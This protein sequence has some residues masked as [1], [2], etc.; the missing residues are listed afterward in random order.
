MPSLMIHCP[1]TGKPLSTGINM[2]AASFAS[3][4]L[5]D[6]TTTCPHCGQPH[7]WNKADVLPIGEGPQEPGGSPK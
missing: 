7:T 3:S 1:K 4:T 5:T 6:N 2:D